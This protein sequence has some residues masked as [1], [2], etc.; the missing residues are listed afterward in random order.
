VVFSVQQLIQQIRFAALAFP[1]RRTGE[2]TRYS[3]EDILLSAF[4]VFFTQAPSFL[5]F[6]R[7]ME[8]QTGRNNATSLFTVHALPS[9]QQIRTVLDGVSPERL[10]PIFTWCFAT[11]AAQG[12]IA[13]FK[14]ELGYLIA[15][16][17]T[18]YFSSEKLHCSQC[19]TKTEKKTGKVSYYHTALTPV[20]VNPD[21]DHVLS[22]PPAFIT[23]Q[24]GETKQDCENKAAKRWLWDQSEY[25]RRLL[26]TGSDVTVLGDDLYS[27]QP[28]IKT[29]QSQQFHNL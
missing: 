2:N 27:R 14:S 1:D 25:G 10:F 16:D 13:A 3:M 17:G 5:S 19:L 18:G 22:L 24:D 8:E 23:P 6:Q 9:D 15:F 12:G 7:A 29:M 20:L 11:L 21:D 28:L 4:S 26:A